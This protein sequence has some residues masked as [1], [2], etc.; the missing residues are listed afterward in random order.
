MSNYH[1]REITEDF[2]TVNIVFHIPIPVGNNAIGL[3]WR[4]VLVRYL[5][6]AANIHS[7]LPEVVNTQEETDMKAGIIFEKLITT[8]FTSTNL[9]DVQRLVQVEAAFTATKAEELAAKQIQLK[10]F[11]KEGSV[12]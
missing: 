10:Y 9:T 3:P 11:G 1:I 6:G 2:K 4:D 7:V 5:G 12:V 8:R